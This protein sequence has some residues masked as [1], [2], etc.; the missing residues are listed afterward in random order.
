[1]AKLPFESFNPLA[2]CV[3]AVLIHQEVAPGPE[4]PLCPL[5]EPGRKEA[6][7]RLPSRWNHQGGSLCK[8][9][10]L[11][12]LAQVAVG[13]VSN[14]QTFLSLLLG[15]SHQ[16]RPTKVYGLE[17][18]PCAFL[19]KILNIKIGPSGVSLAGDTTVQF[20]LLMPGQVTFRSLTWGGLQPVI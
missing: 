4:E 8:A 12:L 18:R 6:A 3:L 7:G 17:F 5:Q 14:S 15:H 1:M 10:F 20:F 2:L 16:K 13:S 19:L 11:F 9:G